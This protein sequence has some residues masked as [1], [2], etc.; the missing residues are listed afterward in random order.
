[1]EAASNNTW[2]SKTASKRTLPMTSPKFTVTY[3]RLCDGGAQEMSTAVC[4]IRNVFEDASISTYRR[5]S[6]EDVALGTP[7]PEV[8][9]TDDN[10]PGD[11][12]TSRVLW[13]S[14][15]R[16]LY[17][18]YPKKRKRSIK[19]IRK[20]L[21]ALRASHETGAVGT[22]SSPS[23]HEKGVVARVVQTIASSATKPPKSKSLSKSLSKSSSP[24]PACVMALA[25]SATSASTIPLPT[26]LDLRRV[27]VV[28]EVSE[29]FSTASE[30]APPGDD[31]A[32]CELDEN[33][34]C[35]I[36]YN[37]NPLR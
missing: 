29:D 13:S 30:A 31:A 10:H 5:T 33:G 12:D 6:Q 37:S 8:V 14:K 18:K 23:S 35:R 28:N 17:Q 15:Q 7:N 36:I 11:T 26:S 27:V 2:E 16:N 19:E 32:N 21:E 20:V 4:A 1:M 34:V 24:R 9:I 25:A 22:S 3:S